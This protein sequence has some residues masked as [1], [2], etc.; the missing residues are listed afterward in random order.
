M[1]CAVVIVNIDGLYVHQE[2]GCDLHK[3]YADF[4]QLGYFLFS[5]RLEPDFVQINVWSKSIAQ[6]P[7]INILFVNLRT[8][9]RQGL[10]RTVHL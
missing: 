1:W 2:I 4:L 5:S 10:H 8:T 3:Y 6:I 7:L 9:E